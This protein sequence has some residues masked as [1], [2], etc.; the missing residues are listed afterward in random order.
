MA[1]EMIRFLLDDQIRS[2]DSDIFLSLDLLERL[3]VINQLKT[4][5]DTLYV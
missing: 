4:Q 1:F 2:S 5:I 3:F